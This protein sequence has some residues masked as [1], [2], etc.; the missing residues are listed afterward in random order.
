[1]VPW[2]RYIPALALAVVL[3]PGPGSASERATDPAD[4]NLPPCRLFEVEARGKPAAHFARE[5][6]IACREIARRRAV[7]R[8][9]GDRLAATEIVLGRY[10]AAMRAAHRE[11]RMLGVPAWAHVA[12]EADKRR[13]ADETGVLTALDYIRNG[14]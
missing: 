6:L 4:G 1:M 8:P 12:T 9:L 11:A 2:R 10:R 13:A 5:A 3:A 7:H 14:Y